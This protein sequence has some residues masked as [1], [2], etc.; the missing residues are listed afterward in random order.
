MGVGFLWGMNFER[1]EIHVSEIR[2]LCD[3]GSVFPEVEGLG[4]M[5]VHVL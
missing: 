1:L 4:D 2:S 5:G 3:M